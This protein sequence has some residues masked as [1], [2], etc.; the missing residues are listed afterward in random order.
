MILRV[1]SAMVLIP[2]T[3][4]A[5][6]YA[7][8][9]L[10]LAILGILGSLCLHEYFHLTR[11][12]GFRGQPWFGHAGLWFFLIGMHESRLPASLVC[13]LV[14][15]AAFLSAM[16]R[17]DSMKDRVTGMMSNLLGIFYLGAGLYSAQAVRFNFG[18]RQGLEW[19]V[20]LLAAVW[21]GDTAAL[22][23][24]KSL[25]RTPFAP[26]LSPN[27]TNEGAVCGL[28]AGMAAAALVQR[29]LF[30]GLPL[31]HVFAASLLIGV[32]AQLGDLAESMLKRA[33]ET[34]E[35]SHLIP[36]HGGVLDRMDSLLFAF[37]VLYLVLQLLYS[38]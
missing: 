2:I 34:K 9:L 25:G 33:A 28:I 16:W 13:A 30:A 31:L 20:V 23:G 8:P 11:Q 18:A 35:S 27:K 17:R 12:L 4:L 22:L 29:F 38:V 10:Y 1:L 15:L 21:M 14:L 19:T 36:G 3:L 32:F 26:R 6:W 37:P 24:G 7:P 5:V